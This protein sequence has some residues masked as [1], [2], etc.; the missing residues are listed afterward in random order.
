[1]SQDGMFVEVSSSLEETAAQV[2]IRVDHDKARQLGVSSEQ[3]RSAL[4]IGFAARQ[5]ATIHE[6]ADSYPVLVQFDPRVSW[7]ARPLDLV[8]IRTADGVMV[9]LSTLV[10]TEHA[11]GPRAIHQLGQLPVV[12]IS[13]DM[14][15]GVSLGQAMDRISAIKRE[16]AL[17]PSVVVRPAG[18]ARVFQHMLNNQALLLTAAVLTIYVVLGILYESFLHPLTILAGLPAAAA[19]A[20]AALHLFQADLGIMGLLGI[21]LLFGIVKKNAIMMIDVAVVRQREGAAPAEAIREACLLRF[22]P[23]LMTTLVALVGSIPIAVGQGASAELRQP[24]GIAVVGG[25]VVSQVLTLFIT[26][27]LYLYMDRLSAAARRVGRI[28]RHSSASLERP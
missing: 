8:S 7:S 21:L 9:P 11:A 2:T 28:G 13:F 4:N 17:P 14:P 16:E 3:I 6:T 12:T 22:R 23:I 20:V 10:T 25:L 18:T 15:A 24:L 5:A 1:M 19:G 26:P 27:V